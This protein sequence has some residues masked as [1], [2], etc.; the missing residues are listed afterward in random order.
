MGVDLFYT[1][2]CID[3]DPYIM[4]WHSYCGFLENKLYIS[5]WKSSTYAMCLFEAKGSRTH[6]YCKLL[7]CFA[8]T[9]NTT[10]QFV[11]TSRPRMDLFACSHK[12]YAPSWEASARK[13]QRMQKGIKPELKNLLYITVLMWSLVVFFATET[14]SA[15]RKHTC[16]KANLIVLFPA[17]DVHPERNSIKPQF[18]ER[19]SFPHNNTGLYESPFQP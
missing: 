11:Y 4:Q 1:S 16:I 13:Q 6:C 18:Y 10:T 8:I 15:L 5:E 17:R 14:V 9:T 19:R 12:L 7:G 3:D 2:V